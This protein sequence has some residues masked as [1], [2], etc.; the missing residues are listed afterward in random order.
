MMHGLKMLTCNKRL[1]DVIGID[2]ES[3]NLSNKDAN[4]SGHIIPQKL[5]V[6]GFW[7]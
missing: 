4:I 1:F 5:E 3:L 6:M 2:M 7:S